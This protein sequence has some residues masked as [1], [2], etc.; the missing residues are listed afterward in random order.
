M[1]YQS[2]QFG[3]F[4]NS[5][6]KVPKID[7]EG[8]TAVVLDEFE[9]NFFGV[10]EAKLHPSGTWM[11]PKQIAAINE[12]ANEN[13]TPVMRGPTISYDGNTLFFFANFGKS[14]FGRE[15]IYFSERTKSGWTKPENVGSNINTDN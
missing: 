15:D 13:M 3:L 7:A 1:V 9:T 14:G 4:V 10:Y 2:D 11:P 5:A 12:Y 8:K 6:K